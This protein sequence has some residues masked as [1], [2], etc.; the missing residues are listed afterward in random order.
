LRGAGK[1]TRPYQRTKTTAWTIQG[2]A[3]DH[4]GDKQK[5]IGKKAWLSQ[6]EEKTTRNERRASVKRE[7]SFYRMM[8]GESKEEGEGKMLFKTQVGKNRNGPGKEGV[9]ET[10]GWRPLG[11]KNVQHRL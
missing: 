3:Y 4:K 7:K 10:G 1:I 5:F 8:G 6:R 11:T 2:G 9:R